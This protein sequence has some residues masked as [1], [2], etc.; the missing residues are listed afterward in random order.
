MNDREMLRGN[1]AIAGA[2]ATKAVGQKSA[3][4]AQLARKGKIVGQFFRVWL[5]DACFEITGRRRVG[6]S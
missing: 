4:A 1:R 3:A 6:S 5:D 2:M